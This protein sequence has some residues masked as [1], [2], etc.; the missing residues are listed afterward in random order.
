MVIKYKYHLLFFCL[1]F[2]CSAQYYDKKYVKDLRYR[3]LLSYF[4][5]RRAIDIN[6]SPNLS[7]DSASKAKLQLSSSSNLFSGLLIQTNN[8][9]LYL[10]KSA[11]QSE[12]DIKKF[13]KQDSKI[14]KAAISKNAIYASLYYINNIGFYDKAYGNH[15]EFIGDTIS[16]RRH[17]DLNFTWF[18]ISLN[19]YD[20]HRQFAIGMPT[21]FGL[22]QLK[23]K[24]TW[25]ARLAYN[26]FKIDNGNNTIF[27]NSINTST[28]DLSILKYAYRGLNVSFVPSFHLIAFKKLF[29]FSDAAIG[30]DLGKV[31]SNLK[32]KEISNRYSNVSISQAN[33]VIGYHNDRF[34]TSVYYSFLNQALKT[35]VM[36]TN[37]VYH[38]FGF[39]IGIRINIYKNLPWEKD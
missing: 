21:Y 15:P 7:S 5:E 17:K 6:V 4:Q 26:S 39:I 24:F 38:N 34:I 27:G 13:G 28:N 18:N 32:T 16:Y 20:Q 10:A 19:Y 8:S 33:V 11:P 31:T 12:N 29:L 25:A 1:P 3:L 14:F 9:S 35:K 30:F 36:T 23:S 2:F 22:R 37:T